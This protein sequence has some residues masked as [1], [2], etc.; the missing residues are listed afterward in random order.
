MMR[1]RLFYP[2]LSL[3]IAIST[4]LSIGIPV[5]TPAIAAD[6]N[7]GN[8]SDP[9]QTANLTY[10]K[11]PT[12]LERQSAAIDAKIARAQAAARLLTLGAPQAGIQAVPTPGGTPDYFGIWPNYANSPLPTVDVNG[13]IVA[14]TGMRKFVDTLP[15]LGPTGANNLGQYIPVANPDTITYPG[16]DYYE[17]AAMQ[18][19]EKMHS[20]LPATTLR[21]YVQLNNGTNSGTNLNT[22]APAPVHYLGPLIIASENRSVRIKFTNL[23]PTTTSGG[24]LFLPVDTTIMGAG[25][26][27]NGGT[28][29]YPD[30]RAVIHLHGGV[31]PWVSDGTAHQWV[32]PG[33]Q[34]T[35]YPQGVSTEDVPDMP[36]QPGGSVTLYYTNQQSARLMFYHDHALGITRLNV[37]DG[38]AAGYLLTD[39]VEQAMVNGGTIPGTTV[40]VPAGTIPVTQV[41]LIIQD[42]T[43]VPQSAQLAAEDP[44]WDSAKWG[45]FGNLWFPHV[46][47]T[48]QNPFVLSGANA[49]GRWDYGPWF[50]PPFTGLQNGP[51]ANPYYDPVNAPWE[52]PQIPGIPN[53]SNTPESFMDTPLVNGTAYPSLTVQPQAYRF[54]IL[55]AGND[56]MLNLSLFKAAPL[57]IGITKAGSGYTSVPVVGITGGSVTGAS[58]NATLGVVGFTVVGG[59]GYTTAPTVTISG[60]GGAGAV[61]AAILTGTSVSSII[62]AASGSGYTSVPSV[63]ISAPP[64][65]GTQATATAL[66]GVVDV[67]VGGGTVSTTGPLV[68]PTITISGGGGA[69]AVAVASVLTDVSMVPA[70]NNPVIPFP[71]DWILPTDGGSVPS[72]IL[73]G[74][75]GG[76]PDPRTM[77]PSWIQIGTEGGFLPAP[78]TIPPMPVGYQYNPR[79]IVIGNVSKHS[80]FLA[81]AERADVIV[82][83]SAYA[84]QTLIL[85]NDSPAPVPAP[86]SRYDYFTGDQDQT[87]SGGAPTTLPGYGPNTR[88][89]M[90][91]K[92][93]AAT[94]VVFNSA[95]LS[96]AIP[97]AFKVSQPPIIVPESAYN[98][99]YGTTYLDNYVKIQ[100]S[101][102]AAP[103]SAQ[104]LSSITITNV[105]AGY[106]TAPLV[107]ITG[108]GGSGAAATAVLSVAGTVSGFTISSIG[109]GYINNPTVTITGGG[110]TGATA[111]AIALNGIIAAIRVTSG[112]SGYTSVPIVTITG[113]GGTGATAT[114][115]LNVGTLSRIN[116]TAPGS[117]YTSAPVVF[118][119]GGG[120]T[121]A[122]AIANL[123][124]T[125]TYDMQ[126]KA[127]QELFTVDYGRMNATLGVE[128]PFTNQ[129]KQTTIPYG[130]ID[131]TTEYIQDSITPMSPV[132]GDGTQVWKITHNGVDTHVIHFHLFD[133]QVI[134]RVGWDGA[135]RAPDANELGWKES[136]RM[137]P[138][139]DCM[140]A[141]RPVAPKLPFGLPDSI[142]PISPTQPIGATMGFFNVAPNGNPVIVTNQL[143]N[144][145]WEY[146]WHCHILGHEENDMMRPIAFQFT[147]AAPAAPVLNVTAT[148]G[149]TLSWN[150]ATPATTGN[151]GN[152]QNEIGFQIQRAPVNGGVVGTYVPIAT[153]LANSTTYVDGTASVGQRYSYRVTAFNSASATNSNT[154][155]VT[156][157][158]AVAAPAVP[159]LTS[160]AGGSSVVASAPIPLVWGAV[161]GATSYNLQILNGATVVVDMPGLISNSWNI[162]NGL[163]A[164]GAFSWK[165]SATGPGGT[166]AYSTPFSMTV[167][168]VS[169][170][171][172]LTAPANGSS[173]SASAPIVLSWNAV[174]G[175]TSY[176]VQ[177]TASGAA[178]PTINV[179][180]ITTANYT[181]TAGTLPRGITYTWQVNATSPGGTSV[182]S[183]PFT[184]RTLR[185]S[186]ADFDGDGKTDI[187]I[188]LPSQ[189]NWYVRQSSNGQPLVQNWWITGATRVPGDYDGDGKTDFAVFNPTDGNWYVRQSSNGQTLVQNWWITG[190]N[191]TQ[192]DYDGDGKTDFAI[193]NSTDGNWYV[194]Q[195]SNGLTLVQNWKI[196]GGILVPGD[197]DGDGKTDFAVFNPADGNWYVRQSSNGL[198]L[199][200]NWF[201]AGAKLVP[202][203]YDGDGKTDFA[204]FNPADGNWY[205]RQSSNGQTLVQNWFITGSTLV[206]ADYDG[207]GKTDFAILYTDGNW[208][209]RQSS[210]GQTLVQNWFITG[211]QTIV[212]TP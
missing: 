35:S 11:R 155:Q 151:L 8:K 102:F 181:I 88:T 66:L 64:A 28:E 62:V 156:T 85:Y 17:I 149:N 135:I 126:P 69:G 46:Y 168:A 98:P 4:V 40:T 24:D 103:A 72:D 10:R 18:Y 117:G 123:T 187:S 107:S 22:V 200:Q 26:G 93:A 89:I 37:Y 130:Y 137:N 150:D 25:T 54:R 48:N 94:P 115:L 165:V 141:L 164:A 91:I 105:G 16:S 113:G 192:G 154:A 23:L 106:T 124:N 152:P 83:F 14:G 183:T 185:G 179:A 92:V 199:I 143:S 104:A 95:P 76:V 202:G 99:V 129:T 15:G 161:T 12:N 203:D 133:V 170:T 55:A 114:A 171:P 21:G 32:A 9:T 163:L 100:D 36:V 139:E 201:F 176:G 146:V 41:P 60:G 59:S 175:A 189:G 127:I 87:A 42:K 180:G 128:L 52:P 145:G 96:T 153:A 77:G 58:A 188:F 71:L 182:W 132:A 140:V 50:W 109:S 125:I 209:I 136:V 197:Y 67:T 147:S 56:R 51:V 45:G 61:G 19:T 31:T 63:A 7:S 68:N 73:N 2:L 134:N 79:N 121:G 174:T 86:D 169:A 118:I 47:M 110:G 90:Q 34:A 172:T 138:L 80:L 211:S 198:T 1:K 204:I 167:P 5:G 108:G 27:P 159:A 29:N 207:D 190:A 75:V 178:S 210:N 184:L 119:S 206:P 44:T 97:A 193:F 144:F 205:I 116:L 3:L 148:S 82:D 208:Y 111:D 131:P 166:S 195:S 13:N 173:V 120:G 101:D 177:V 78:V 74:R 112:G 49:M 39:S 6:N 158:T 57:T 70:V 30:N 157:T 84:G 194:R 81:P 20:D 186:V 196:T 65:G 53:P 38:L 142:R 191:L 43:F 212:T 162:P 160:P 33:L 122:T